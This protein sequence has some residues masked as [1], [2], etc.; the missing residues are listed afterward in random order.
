[1]Y[2]IFSI[3]YQSPVL[4]AFTNGFITLLID[5][6]VANKVHQHMHYFAV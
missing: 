4:K 6:K 5:V 3:M 1:M 2:C